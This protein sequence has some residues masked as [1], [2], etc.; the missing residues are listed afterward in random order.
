MASVETRLS[1]EDMAALRRA[2]REEIRAAKEATDGGQSVPA[3][4]PEASA[5]AMSD[6][7]IQVYDRA[8]A[9]IDQ[10]L[11]RG[12]WTEQDR[13]RLRADLGSLP[14]DR[15]R[16]LIETLFVAINQQK[17]RYSGH[18]PPM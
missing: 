15:R 16:E 18:G 11:E 2:I 5:D 7:A 14:A 9:A 17:V 8:H 13:D 4:S 10:A 6:E 1:D 12:S 3:P